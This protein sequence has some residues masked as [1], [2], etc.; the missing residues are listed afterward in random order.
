[1]IKLTSVLLHYIFIFILHFKTF[2][3]ITE[4]FLYKCLKEELKIKK[5][6][7]IAGTDIVE[8][9]ETLAPM[10]TNYLYIKG[11]CGRDESCKQVE[12]SSLYQCFPKLKKLKIGDAC[13]VNEECY[14]G[15]CSM[16]ICM[17]VDFEADC[18]DYPKGCKPGTYCAYNSF[19][20]KSICVE[21]ASINEIC[22]YSATLGY[23]IECF[24]GTIC[25]VRDDNSG[26]TVCKK[27]G[28]FNLNKEVTDERLC[29]TGMALVDTEVDNKLKCIGVEEDSECDQ[30]TH[31]CNPIVV[32]IGP[33]PDYPTELN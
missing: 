15:F 28:T 2:V 17:G 1:M 24:P 29:Q 16:S 32:G 8:N 19:L 25:Q 6:C 3:S 9:E 5:I 31:K 30:D 20:D 23:V 12:D 26:T 27:W 10:T 7:A 18:S 4:P 14:T 22:G 13:S 33:N 21:Y 11:M